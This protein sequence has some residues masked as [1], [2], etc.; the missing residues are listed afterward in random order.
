MIL[1]VRRM[2]PEERE[3]VMSFVDRAEENGGQKT[4]WGVFLTNAL[5]LGE[6]RIISLFLL[7][8]SLVCPQIFGWLRSDLGSYNKMGIFPTVAR[9]NHSCK[10]N[11]HHFFNPDT[12]EEE[13]GVIINWSTE[14]SSW[15]PWL[16]SPPSCV[17]TKIIIITAI[18]ECHSTN[19]VSLTFLSLVLLFSIPKMSQFFLNTTPF[20]HPLFIVQL[21]C[22]IVFGTTIGAGSPDDLNWSIQHFVNIIKSSTAASIADNKQDLIKIGKW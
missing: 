7:S 1:K 5:P 15:S 17:T 8:S 20:C 3:T 18:G 13:V 4:P 6:I 14:F 22:P 16:S 12:G 9:I 11:A 10:P 21:L 19:Y 2:S